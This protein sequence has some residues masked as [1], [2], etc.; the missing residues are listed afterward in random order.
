MSSSLQPRGLQHARLPCPSLSPWVC[1][2][3]CPLSRWCHPTSSSS[4]APFSSC[5][6]YLP[7]LGSFPVSQLFDQVAKEL[8]IQHQSFQWIFRV[9]FLIDWFDL[10]A[11]QGT[12]KRVFSNTTVQKHQFFGAQPSSWSKSHIHTWLLEKL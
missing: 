8:E 11:V 2:N 10:L 12:L 1:S 3:L 9:N 4:V 7:V 6:Q 5:P